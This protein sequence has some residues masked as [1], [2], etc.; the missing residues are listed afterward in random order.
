MSF[1]V[2][3]SL[4]IVHC[5]WTIVSFPVYWSYS[6][7]I[8]LGPSSHS[9]FTDLTDRSLLFDHR[10]ISC[11]LVLLIVHCSWTIVSFPVYWS[12]LIVHCS[13]TIV[14]FPVY[15]SYSSFIL[16]GPSSHSLFTD[17]TDRSLL[18]DHRLIPCTG[19]IA[20]IALGPSSHSLF[21]GL[22]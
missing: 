8:L 13:W 18:F 11:L 9:L 20:F 19:L 14:S 3:W 15:W 5:S 22:Y 17:L 7:F 2:Y 1:P 10:L 6:S 12:L 21:T 16:L 4:L